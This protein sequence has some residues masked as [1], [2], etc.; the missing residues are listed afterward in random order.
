MTT[1]Q[2]Q[3]GKNPQGQT[4]SQA[5]AVAGARR[6]RGSENGVQGEGNYDATRRFDKAERE[7][8]ESGKVDEAARAAK[9]RNAEEAEELA[10]AEREA[11]SHSKG[12]DP[13]DDAAMSS[14]QKSDAQGSGTS[15]K[16]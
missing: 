12:D 11:R 2:N 4:Q 5:A 3:T 16:K 13:K 14:S 15:P 9:P 10:R 7:F 8:V 1:P 6:R